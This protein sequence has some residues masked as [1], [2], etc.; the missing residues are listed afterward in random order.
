MAN[1]RQK[2]NQ[3]QDWIEKWIVEN[4]PGSVI[5]N[6]KTVSKMIKVRDKKSGKFKDVWISARNDIFGAIDLIVCSP[7][8]GLRFIQ[9]TMD[10]H[11][12]KRQKELIAIPWPWGCC[13]VELWLKKKPGEVHVKRMSED[14][15]F[16][17]IGK[18]LRGKF[19]RLDQGDLF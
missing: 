15:E 3:F 2:G 12:G 13:V 19:Y 1:K 7:A 5:H 8:D 6:Q 18:I 9:A 11:I 4:C 16:Y 14:G 17:D 10:S